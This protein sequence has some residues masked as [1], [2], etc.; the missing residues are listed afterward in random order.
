MEAYKHQI[1]DLPKLLLFEFSKLLS[2]YGL[3]ILESHLKPNYLNTR[4]LWLTQWP[5]SPRSR[6]TMHNRKQTISDTTH[7]SIT[8]KE[9]FFNCLFGEICDNMWLGKIERSHHVALRYLMLYPVNDDSLLPTTLCDVDEESMSE[10]YTLK[11]F[12]DYLSTRV[13]KLS[14]SDRIAKVMF[15]YVDT[16][17]PLLECVEQLVVH[18]SR[19]TF[20]GA[21]SMLSCIMMLRLMNLKSIKISEIAGRFDTSVIAATTFCPANILRIIND[22]N[23]IIPDT[24][25]CCHGCKEQRHLL[26]D[27]VD[28]L[29]ENFTFTLKNESEVVCMEL[30]Q[31]K[32]SFQFLKDLYWIDL[33]EHLESID[34][35]SRYGVVDDFS[36]ATSNDDED[37]FSCALDMTDGLAIKDIKIHTDI[38][39][40]QMNILPS[41][42]ESF[43]LLIATFP[44]WRS[45]KKLDLD[46]LCQI[47]EEDLEIFTTKLVKSLISHRKNGG[48]LEEL[49]VNPLCH[50]AHPSISKLFSS[51]CSTHSSHNHISQSVKTLKTVAPV[52]VAFALF[53]RTEVCKRHT[54]DIDGK[55][56]LDVPKS[57]CIYE[58][59][60]VLEVACGSLWGILNTLSVALNLNKTLEEL[61]VVAKSPE[62][63]ELEI[64]YKAVAHHPKISKFVLNSSSKSYKNTLTGT[65]FLVSLLEKPLLR[66]LTINECHESPSLPQEM[67]SALATCSHL[68]TFGWTN[69]FLS[70]NGLHQL[71]EVLKEKSNLPRLQQLDIGGNEY[72]VKSLSEFASALSSSRRS[73]QRLSVCSPRITHQI[74][75]VNNLL[76]Q[77]MEQ[78]EILVG[79]SGMSDRSDYIAQ[80]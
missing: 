51:Y 3:D 74:L 63:E 30:A 2:P 37:L 22:E 71:S 10:K 52:P 7:E 69:N 60:R 33:V 48:F 46:F 29:Y 28:D 66:Y 72:S 14:V 18:T 45:L 42:P 12:V 4:N 49:V 34:L 13:H 44:N 8:P 31:I 11:W 36:N 21:G 39:E 16:F 78:T 53:L 23:N 68:S 5:P 65:S 47:N 61:S 59:L 19:K 50:I 41:E 40:F 76:E 35:V 38:T 20:S 1:Q 57:P 25:D 67:I 62:K 58:G 32:Q 56:A 79:R 17:K 15:K 9:L 24:F 43:E 6:L 77:L 27:D 80:M 75:E 26:C 70:D 55:I 73:F 64:L 54:I